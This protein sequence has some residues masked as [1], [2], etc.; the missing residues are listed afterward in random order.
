[1]KDGKPAIVGWIPDLERASLEHRQK[2][3]AF[4][5]KNPEWTT[6]Y[7]ERFDKWVQRYIEG[8]WNVDNG[9]LP[10]LVHV[11]EVINALTS[12]IVGIPLYKHGLSISL[13]YPAAENTHRYQDA[14][15]ELYGYLVDCITRSVLINL[16]HI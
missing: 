13:S 8:S 5:L 9:P 11:I 2:W 7:D 12:E 4:Q 10:H 6:E 3:G 1:M 15:E 14:H 16:H